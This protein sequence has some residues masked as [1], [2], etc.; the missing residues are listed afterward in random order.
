M[1]CW[2][3]LEEDKV[4]QQQQQWAL[5]LF[6]PIRK[7]HPGGGTWPGLGPAPP[8]G[9]FLWEGSGGRTG[10][11]CLPT[12][13]GKVGRRRQKGVREKSVRGRSAVPQCRQASVL[14]ISGSEAR[15]DF[16]TKINI[17]NTLPTAG[18]AVCP[19]AWL[20]E[21]MLPWHHSPGCSPSAALPARPRCC[22]GT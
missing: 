15:S 10:Q 6:F 13:E 1:L 14:N 21:G 8:A 19:P 20:A 3:E 11:L 18:K 9:I 16:E 17:P 7:V 22:Q 5:L 2:L 4:K 12:G